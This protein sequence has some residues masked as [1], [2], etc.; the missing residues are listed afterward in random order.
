VRLVAPTSTR[1]GSV[2]RLRS[3][4]RAG[5]HDSSPSPSPPP[6]IRRS[7]PSVIAAIFGGDRPCS[8]CGALR[9]GHP[10]LRDLRRARDPDTRPVGRPRRPTQAATAPRLVVD[11]FAFARV[12]GTIA[13]CG[14]TTEPLGGLQYAFGHIE[15]SR[16]PQTRLVLEPGSF[17]FPTPPAQRRRA[18]RPRWAQAEQR[19]SALQSP[20]CGARPASWS[21]RS[22]RPTSARRADLALETWPMPRVLANSRSFDARGV[23]GHRLVRLGDAT[24][25]IDAGVTAVVE[26]GLTPTLAAE[27]PADAL[28]TRGRPRCARPGPS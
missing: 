5:A 16:S 24:L 22:G 18:T 19:A 2:G 10:R 28:R 8:R 25:G 1:R 4:P 14:C 17:L 7:L 9:L 13:P 11:I 23:Q 15:A 3:P 6:R 21:R 12:L 27:A 20:V 26:P